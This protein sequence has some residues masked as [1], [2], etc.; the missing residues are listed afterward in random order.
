MVF[1][2]ISGYCPYKCDTRKIIVEYKPVSMAG[3]L[4]PGYKKTSMNCENYHECQ[5]LDSFGRCPLMVNA[6]AEP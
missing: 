6:P 4:K 3:H 2:Q 1:K 5:N